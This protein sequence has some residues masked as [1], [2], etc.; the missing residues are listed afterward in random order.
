M[1]LLTNHS[2][3]SG[4]R[5][6]TSEK[7]T[8]RDST[9]KRLQKDTSN[10]AK[11][12]GSGQTINTSTT[13]AT[14]KTTHAATEKRLLKKH[15]SGTVTVG[16]TGAREGDILQ[17]C[18]PDTNNVILRVERG[19]ME[20]PYCIRQAVEAQVGRDTIIQRMAQQFGLSNATAAM[21]YN[22]CPVSDGNTPNAQPLGKACSHTA[23]DC[24]PAARFVILN[25]GVWQE[26][27]QEHGKEDALEE[28]VQQKRPV[29]YRDV[30][31]LLQTKGQPGGKTLV[32]R[33]KLFRIVLGPVVLAE[34]DPRLNDIEGIGP[35]HVS[36][37]WAH[38]SV[39]QCWHFREKVSN[40]FW[41]YYRL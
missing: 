36:R 13:V 15:F 23:C 9:K 5:K 12:T 1:L 21:R 6:R 10:D 2:I 4:K 28:M 14:T 16:L 30:L 27:A 40:H 35:T 22:D 18:A 20:A 41:V 8:N 17:G 19:I 29:C 34:T 31:E 7:P 38:W 24:E 33:P 11:A 25:Q 26:Y 37:H 32:L 39:H 3:D